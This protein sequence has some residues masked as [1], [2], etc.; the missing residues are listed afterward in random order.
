MNLEKKR[1]RDSLDI[2]NNVEKQK[3]KEES[4]NFL[5]KLNQ[6][7]EN[8]KFYDYYHYITNI[9]ITHHLLDN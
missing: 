7:L 8:P 2:K 5:I 4:P 1:N 3:E 6:I 9:I